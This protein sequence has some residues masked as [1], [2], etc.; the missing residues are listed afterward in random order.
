MAKI[1]SVEPREKYHLIKFAAESDREPWGTLEAKVWNSEPDL[2]KKLK[3]NSSVNCVLTSTK[4][5]EVI[6]DVEIIKEGR[7]GLSDKQKNDAYVGLRN[8]LE[9]IY[10]DERE[11]EK[12]RQMA[13]EIEKLIINNNW[14]FIN[15]PAAKTH[16]HNYI[17][18]LIQHT[19]EVVIDVPCYNPLAVM[20]AILHDF[21][22]IYEYKIDTETGI[23]EYNTDFRDKLGLTKESKI[24]PHILWAYNWCIERGFKELAHI[25]GSHHGT[26][27]HG[28]IFKPATPE[29]HLLYI[30][31]YK[32]A[33]LGALTVDELPEEI[34]V[35]NL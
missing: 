9:N 11:P 35:E 13:K 20:G 19:E 33:H 5:G 25:V 2:I 12:I 22:K 3:L 31:D 32:S 28:S 23:V 10:C 15:A 29:A 4:Y 7:L 1:I 8:R 34:T 26:V 16:H 14:A 21:G 24:Y 27:E 18:G 30:A 6:N 17:G